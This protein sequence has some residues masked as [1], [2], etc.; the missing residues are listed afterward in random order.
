MLNKKPTKPSESPALSSS[1]GRSNPFKV[2]KNSQN[3]NPARSKSFFDSV[4]EDK[5]TALETAASKKKSE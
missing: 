2:L 4:E 1:Q 5:K 3:Q